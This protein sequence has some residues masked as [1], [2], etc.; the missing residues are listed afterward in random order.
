M[1]FEQ[2]LKQVADLYE[3]QGYAVTLRPGGEELPPFA[4]DFKVEI[5]ARRDSGGVLVS[6]K[7]NREEF[8]TDADVPRYA[9]LTPQHPGW[10]FDF[11]ILG[12]ESPTARDVRGAKEPSENLIA[13]FLS[14][15]EALLG[16]GYSPSALL[17]AWSGL[18]AAMRRRLQA[19]GEEVGW[20]SAAGEM[21]SQL[22]SAGIVSA[23]EFARLE[24]ASRQRNVLAHG[25]VGPDVDAETVRFLIEIAKR[26]LQ[27]SQAA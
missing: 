25:F 1:D 20:G 21:L 2:G 11:A 3:K 5:L 10:R 7:K 8:E 27:E 17:I 14:H 23:D 19:E 4:K 18:E 13:S 15:A 24:L 22:N 12:K 6:V 26:L 9:E 16:H